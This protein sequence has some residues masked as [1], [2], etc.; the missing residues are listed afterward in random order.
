MKTMN[1][2]DLNAV[3]ANTP[4][5]L[6]ELV[7]WVCWNYEKNKDGKPT[8]VPYRASD[9]QR[10]SSMN[11]DDWCTFD[12]ACS[13]F[14]SWKYT[15]I[16]FVFAEADGLVGVDLDGC[17]GADGALTP[18]AKAIVE[19]LDSY[20]ELSPS[21]TGVKIF[22]RGVKPG[23]RCRTGKIAGMEGIEVYGGGRYFTVTGQRLP[24][25]RATIENR[26]PQINALWHRLFGEEGV[27]LKAENGRAKSDK[28]EHLRTPLVGNQSDDELLETIRKSSQGPKFVSLWAGDT[29]AYGGDDSRADLGLCRILAK[30][31]MKDPA[32]IDR[33]FRRSGL[34]RAK[35]DEPR[36]AMTYG[37]KTIAKAMEGGTGGSPDSGR[38][39]QRAVPPT[40]QS[41]ES[42]LGRRDPVTGCLV[43]A[44]RST[45]PTA[46]AFIDEFFKHPEGVT[47]YCQAEVLLQWVGNRYVV[48]ERG[49]IERDLHRW[50]HQARRP[51]KLG[52]NELVPFESN[53]LTFK[54]A[55][56]AVCAEQFLPADQPSP[57][58]L[59]DDP[60]L[61]N[62][63]EL[64]PCKS[65][66]VHLPTGN[67][68]PPT[69]RLFNRNA[70][71]FDCEASPP[72]PARWL[73]FLKES[74]GVDPEAIQLLQ[75]WMGYLLTADTRHQK[76][77]LVIGPRRSGK[78][79]LAR[80]ITKL[81]GED[82]VVAPSSQGL[83][84]RFGLQP[85]L[86]KTLAIM[87]DVR[88]DELNL[89]SLSETLLA[90]SGEDSVTV[91]RKHL[92][93]VTV[94]LPTRFMLM[95]NGLPRF[96]DSSL[97]LPGRFLVLETKQ[98]FFGK[99]DT[100][101]DA[102]LA[103]ELPGILLWAIEGWKLLRERGMFP[104]PSSSQ[105]IIDELNSVS[106]PI[107]EFLGQRCVFG[108]RDSVLALALFKA[109]SS[110]CDETGES[111]G[112]VQQFGSHLREAIPSLTSKRGTGQKLVYLGI[113]LR[114]PAEGDGS[115]PTEG[116]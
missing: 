110:W 39:E 71:S 44:P 31:T 42:E 59:T 78:G 115:L 82:N 91:H 46:R 20:T 37:E 76:M 60:A 89:A 103:A 58:W 114:E 102:K 53:P 95:A 72:T 38:R 19:E 99:E 85:L 63:D 80:L 81:V 101:L 62:C 45:L 88:A 111:P 22:M 33:I 51:K 34:M 92:T 75:M 49:S 116:E 105:H 35:W 79:T 87:G 30:W 67:V 3:R 41:G 113:G 73:Q 24:G 90:I 17:V 70:L 50:L 84:D 15:G 26:G 4:N 96:R 43:L 55:L 54:A 108:K 98:S 107:R 6:K 16:G 52:S 25:V 56:E 9:G 65:G 57:S 32:Q 100:E 97:A 104:V 83:A 86:G 93:S 8:K 74:F 109:W 48:I 5:D 28:Q 61:P 27:P 2:L 29:S 23:S 14:E 64:L 21:G 66:T 106:S 12:E 36:G 40:S 77:L 112:T 94:R 11:P 69:P 13:A 18:E 68:H 7:G 10:A 1:P 47:L